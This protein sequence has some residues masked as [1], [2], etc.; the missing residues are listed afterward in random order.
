MI[1]RFIIFA[2]LYLLAGCCELTKQP[3][4]NVS[5]TH[6]ECSSKGMAYITTVST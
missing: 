5:I 1:Y 4:R 6:T 3:G 2:F